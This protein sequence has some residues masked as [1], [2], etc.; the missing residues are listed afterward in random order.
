M[1][2]VSTLSTLKAHHLLYDLTT[3]CSSFFMIFD[4][5]IKIIRDEN[6]VVF[7]GFHLQLLPTGNGENE[8]INGQVQKLL[9]YTIIS[10]LPVIKIKIKNSYQLH[11]FL[12]QVARK[13]W[14]EFKSKAFTRPCPQNLDSRNTKHCSTVS[15][16]LTLNEV[17][18]VKQYPYRLF[19]THVLHEQ[20]C[21][22][23]NINSPC[24]R[25]LTPLLF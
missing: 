18:L 23:G 9:F 1:P 10:N 13:K 5:Q 15:L 7:F 16:F 8:A 14:L 4:Q 3:S 24:V 22:I 19:H 25:C 2:V 11:C 12:H 20:G 21:A 6:V 17:Y